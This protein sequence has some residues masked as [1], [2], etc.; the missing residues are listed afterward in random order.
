VPGV[1]LADGAAALHTDR[2]A[3]SCPAASAAGSAGQLGP[4]FHWLRQFK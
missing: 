2:G 4:N 3:P 1:R